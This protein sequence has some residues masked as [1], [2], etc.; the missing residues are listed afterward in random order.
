MSTQI[1]NLKTKNTLIINQ[2]AGD[3]CET[4]CKKEHDLGTRD[5]NICQSICEEERKM[6][7]EERDWLKQ[8]SYLYPLRIPHNVNYLPTEYVGQE[9]YRQATGQDFL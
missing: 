3:F 9:L 2:R 1:I 8:K 4:R 6:Y 7:I 5:F